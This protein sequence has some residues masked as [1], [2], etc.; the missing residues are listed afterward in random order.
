[1]E[2]AVVIMVVGLLILC[3]RKKISNLESVAGG[4]GWGRKREDSQKQNWGIHDSGA[5]HIFADSTW[6][7]PAIAWSAFA[8]A[9]SRPLRFVSI[10][11]CFYFYYHCY[12][13]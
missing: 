10:V 8:M 5:P 2:E 9:T 1:M 12:H 6:T 3:R 4:D 11:A 13:N 7:S